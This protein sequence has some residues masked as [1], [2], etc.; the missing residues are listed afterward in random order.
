M[1]RFIVHISKGY[2]IEKYFTKKGRLW[3]H[4]FLL[5]LDENGVYVSTRQGKVYLTPENCEVI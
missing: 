5:F 2:A 1:K 4:N 3:I